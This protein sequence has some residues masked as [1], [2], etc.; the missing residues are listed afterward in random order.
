MIAFYIL[1]LVV[2][3]TYIAA[4]FGRYGVMTSISESYYFMP[5][6]YA[7]PFFYGFGVLTALPLLI[8]W[9]DMSP[10]K[11][12]FLVFLS[13]VPLGFVGAAGAFKNADVTTR[14][15]YIAAGCC[16]LFSQLWI[17]INTRWWICSLILLAV[18]LVLTWRFKGK[19]ADGN[20]RSA[21]LYFVELAAFASIYI[22]LLAYYI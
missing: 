2:F 3:A 14:V 13:C 15:H 11:W 8:F 6:K 9:L 16:A 1:S 20:T 10:E 5:K 12:Q 4:T 21:W 17:V 22:A 19:D 7:V 18:A